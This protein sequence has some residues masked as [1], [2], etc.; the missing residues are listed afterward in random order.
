MQT[1]AVIPLEDHR[2]FKRC[3][4]DEGIDAV[5]FGRLEP[6]PGVPGGQKVRVRIDLRPRILG[7]GI[8]LR[9]SIPQLVG[10]DPVASAAL[11]EFVRRLWRS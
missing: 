8:G 3:H 1:I 11:R 4:C 6:I 2:L 9:K 5:M 10:Y 7:R